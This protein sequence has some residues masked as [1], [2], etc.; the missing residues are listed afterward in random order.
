MRSYI[1]NFDQIDKPHLITLVDFS[2]T[3]NDKRMWILNFAFGKPT[4]I[5]HTW[6]AHG[7][8]SGGANCDEVGRKDRKSCVG[9]FVTKHTWKSHLGQKVKSGTKT[10]RAMCLIGLDPTNDNARNRGIRWH[11]AWYVKPN[12]VKNSWGCICPPQDVHDK[13]VDHLAGGSFVFAYK[14]EDSIEV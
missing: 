5:T 2:R 12:N 9:G 11:G 7:S 8:G 6:C 3:R 14:D 13:L 10:K 4:L 1:K